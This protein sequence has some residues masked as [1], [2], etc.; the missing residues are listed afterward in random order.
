MLGFD[1]MRSQ[2]RQFL[3]KESKFYK[4]LVKD[5]SSDNSLSNVKR[6]IEEMRFGIDQTRLFDGKFV[7]WGVLKVKSSPDQT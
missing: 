6:E 7:Q 4:D 5:L 1:T 2:E 3:I